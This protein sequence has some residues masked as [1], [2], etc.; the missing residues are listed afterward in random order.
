MDNKVYRADLDGIKGI[1]I[2]AVILFHM[3]LVKSGYLGVDVF[4]VINGYLIIPKLISKITEGD[5]SY[6]KFIQKR[7]GRLLP[8]VV[9]LTT[10]SM[11]VGAILCYHLNMNVWRVL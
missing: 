4:F 6:M 5:F 1:A 9:I 7:I 8:L 10:V 2:L 11:I 3:G